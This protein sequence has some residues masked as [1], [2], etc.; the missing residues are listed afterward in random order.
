MN[1]LFSSQSA[2][3]I[4]VAT[5]GCVIVAAYLGWRGSSVSQQGEWNE[6]ERSVGTE[7]SLSSELI[8]SKLS[9]FE[10]EAFNVVSAEYLQHSSH[11]P[12]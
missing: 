7:L 12:E 3:R 4:L 8:S 6:I 10:A 9:Q 1:R 5:I 11:T 2:K